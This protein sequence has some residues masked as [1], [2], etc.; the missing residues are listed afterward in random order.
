MAK[1][2]KKGFILP[3]VTTDKRKCVKIYIPDEV[4]DRGAF[5]GALWELTFS[6]NWQLGSADYAREHA[7]M[8]REIWTEAYERSNGMDCCNEG[9]VL[10]RYNPDTG[11][12]EV[13]YTDGATWVDDPADIQ[14]QIPLYPP[15]VNSTSGKTKCDA[16]TNGSEHVNELIEATAENLSAASSIFALAVGIAEAILALF[17][18]I[19]S[20]GTLTA[21]VTAVATAIWAAATSLFSLGITAYNAYWTADKKDAILCAIY[22]NI[23]SDGQFTEAQYQAFRTKVKNTLPA[24]PALDIIMTAINAGGARGLSQMCSYGNAALA[25]C[26]SCDCVEGCPADKWSVY[27]GGGPYFGE[28]LEVGDNWLIAQTTNVNTNGLY[29]VYLV[30]DDINDCCFVVPANFELIE[31]TAGFNVAP[32]GS[33]IG[34][35]LTGFFP[36]GMCI[37]QIQPQSSA[38][39]KFKVTFGDCPP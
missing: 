9:S 30:T 2:N 39:F 35:G 38:P 15:L 22:C 29:Y 10:H 1:E 21:P 13:S 12:P 33:A 7:D 6:Y 23:G 26:S 11:R 4:Y 18:I 27:A 16:A 31:G 14:N 32:C 20:A 37:N 28:I 36:A 8:W 25:D 34:T 19:I 5:W 3:P 17:L 24:S